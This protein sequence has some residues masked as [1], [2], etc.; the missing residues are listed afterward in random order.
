MQKLGDEGVLNYLWDDTGLG[1][2]SGTIAM[3]LD[4]AG[5]AGFLTIQQTQKLQVI[6]SCSCSE[7]IR[8]FENWL[9]RITLFSN[10]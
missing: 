5:W 7:R 3:N 6:W 1:F 9:V 2:A 4:W 10:D 8:W